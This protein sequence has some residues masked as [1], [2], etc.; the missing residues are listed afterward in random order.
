MNQRTKHRIYNSLGSFVGEV[1]IEPGQ[2]PVATYAVCHM[3]EPSKLLKI[4]Y[5]AR[6][7]EMG[8]AMQKIQGDGNR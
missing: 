4:G 3:V 1:E 2:D 5:T 8:E 7:V 6:A